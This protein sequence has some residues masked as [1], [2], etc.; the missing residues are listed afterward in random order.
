ME[1]EDF[2]KNFELETEILL[3]NILK[4]IK[5]IQISK[6]AEDAVEN[7][8][9]FCVTLKK[10]VQKVE[11]CLKG[12]FTGNRRKRAQLC[13]S[14]IFK[15]LP[16][17]SVALQDCQEYNPVESKTYVLKRLEASFS[18]LRSLLAGGTDPGADAEGEGG[19]FVRTM[20]AALQVV[21]CLESHADTPAL[22]YAVQCVSVAVQDVLSRAIYISQVSCHARKDE[23]QA[24]CAKVSRRLQDL[25]AECSSQRRS[26]TAVRFSGEAL[27]AA[28]EDLEHLVNKTL[29]HLF[30]EVFSDPFDVL[31]R[32]VEACVSSPLPV[33]YRKSSDLLVLELDRHMERMIVLGQFAVAC[34]ENPRR[35]LGMRSCVASLESL[36][37]EMVAALTLMYMQPRSRRHRRH[38]DL[39]MRHYKD[40]VVCLRGLLD[41]VVDPATFCSVVESD[42]RRLVKRFKRGQAGPVAG[43]R[44]VAEEMVRKTEMLLHLVGAALELDEMRP[45]DPQTAASVRSL[46]KLAGRACGTSQQA[47]RQLSDGSQDVHKERVLKRLKMIVTY[48]GR[49]S[50]VLEEL[51]NEYHLSAVKELEKY[52]SGVTGESSDVS[53]SNQPT[54]LLPE[55]TCAALLSMEDVVMVK[56]Q[57][58]FSRGRYHSACDAEDGDVFSLDFT[59]IL[60]KLTYLEDTFTS[61][62]HE[63]SSTSSEARVGDRLENVEMDSPDQAGRPG[64]RSSV[65]RG[66]GKTARTVRSR[67]QHRNIL[68]FIR[69]KYCRFRRT[70]RCGTGASAVGRCREAAEQRPVNGHAWSPPSPSPVN[71]VPLCASVM[72]CSIQEVGCPQTLKHLCRVG[73]LCGLESARRHCGQAVSKQS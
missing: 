33:G 37:T 32:L 45:A 3:D 38:L 39:L 40:E 58:V 71:G 70:L 22:D 47:A 67:T 20:N 8:K 53:G 29:L 72:N 60:E 49:M 41:T 52:D 35:V 57:M 15:C 12:L 14:Q 43:L 1:V 55:R 42:I 28:L 64:R 17:L 10:L 63:A 30:L 26:H 50:P 19:R 46:C 31:W 27:R 62:A 13:I 18:E 44:G 36:D 5:C 51:M 6:T 68:K 9:A 54:C 66:G 25:S 48:V 34:S 65:K 61:V 73:S 11:V 7:F 59:G 2:S 21:S 23:F 69:K 24:A 56:P 16:I 4:I